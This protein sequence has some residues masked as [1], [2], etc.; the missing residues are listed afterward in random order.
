MMATIAVTDENFQ[1]IT[2]GGGI[3]ILD[4]WATWCGACK[5]FAPIYWSERDTD[6][7]I[8]AVKAHNA[9]WRALC[10]PKETPDAR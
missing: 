2:G 4:F 3:V 1:E 7:T 8:L 6:E 9:A 10:P 5:A